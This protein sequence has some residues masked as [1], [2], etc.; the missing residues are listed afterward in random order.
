MGHGKER[1]GHDT[2]DFL[3][4]PAV[5]PTHGRRHALYSRG[6]GEKGK[7]GGGGGEEEEG[8]RATELRA[9][10]VLMRDQINE[11]C[12]LLGSWKRARR[13]AAGRKGF[14]T[15]GLCLLEKRFLR[16]R[17]AM[18]LADSLDRGD[19]QAV[20]RDLE[21][22]LVSLGMANLAG[23]YLADA[24][25]RIGAWRGFETPDALV[26]ALPVLMRALEKLP[27]V[28]GAGFDETTLLDK[29]VELF[30]T[31]RARET[32]VP[33]LTSDRPARVALGCLLLTVPCKG[34]ATCPHKR[35]L[36]LL[37]SFLA[38]EKAAGDK[39]A[40]VRLAGLEGEEGGKRCM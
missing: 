30:S 5:R 6:R 4:M 21:T 11:S 20:F 19:D 1:E 26:Y 28:L 16:P 14:I 37:D 9:A 38:A 7:G 24:M 15:R 32:V 22:A 40:A 2:I 35:V 10:L 17:T 18:E 23:E 27:G 12:A 25:V 31:A 13:G 29:V 33:A 3:A 34:D 39:G 36:G 8:V